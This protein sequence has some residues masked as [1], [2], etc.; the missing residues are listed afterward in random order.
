MGILSRDYLGLMYGTSSNIPEDFPNGKLIRLDFEVTRLFD[1]K[2]FLC[3]VQ[4]G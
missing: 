3:V 1:L 2:Q 4:K